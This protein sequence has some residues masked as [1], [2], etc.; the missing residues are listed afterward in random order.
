MFVIAI[1]VS[2]EFEEEALRAMSSSPVEIVEFVIRK[3]LPFG[4]MPPRRG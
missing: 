3:L 4:S 1:L 2:G